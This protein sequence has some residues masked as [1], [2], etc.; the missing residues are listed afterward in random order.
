MKFII[1]GLGSFGSSLGMALTSQGH[2]VIAIDS[3]MQKVETYKE[4]IT[5]TICMDATDE[6]TVNGLPIKDT[7]IVVVAIG[8]DQGANVMAT[9]LFK[10]LNARRLI[11]RSINPLH[12]K[13]LQAIGV[14][15]IFHPEKEAAMRWAKRLSLRY[16]VDSFELSDNFSIVEISIPTDLIGRTIG[17]LQLEHRFNI[18][19]LSTMC[20]EHYEDSFGRMQTKPNI[21][22]LAAP[23]QVLQDD[24]VLIIYGAN[25]HI[26]KFLRSVG[27]KAH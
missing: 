19:L 27:V 6:Y 13:V 15:D 21:Q 24:D 1:A 20:H 12:E 23:E 18:K 26:N 7:D 9:A 22:G 11:S 17:E 16:F 14:D 2:E 25:T 5:H 8:E 3:S 4:V 10:T